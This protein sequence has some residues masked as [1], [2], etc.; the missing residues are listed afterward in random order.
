MDQFSVSFD[1]CEEVDEEETADDGNQ[2][3]DNTEQAAETEE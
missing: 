2:E 3:A 1:F